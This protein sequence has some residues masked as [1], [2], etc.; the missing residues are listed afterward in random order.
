MSDQFYFTLCINFG[1]DEQDKHEQNIWKIKRA[2]QK[3]QNKHFSW[4]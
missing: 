4:T 2:E 1:K 3:I